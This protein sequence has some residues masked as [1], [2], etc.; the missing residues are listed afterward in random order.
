[1]EL[2]NIMPGV[3]NP[4]QVTVYL[5][6]TH[7]IG[8]KQLATVNPVDNLDISS[9]LNAI[10]SVTIIYDTAPVRSDFS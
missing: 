2:K 8:S 6:Y 7:T 4:N 1:M 10:S 3:T 9:H 5:S